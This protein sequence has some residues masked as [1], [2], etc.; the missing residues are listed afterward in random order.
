MYPL[1]RVRQEERARVAVTRGNQGWPAAAAN[2]PGG[3]QSFSKEAPLCRKAKLLG[4]T[5][6]LPMKQ[7]L[8]W[9]FYHQ[10]APGMY[11][12]YICARDHG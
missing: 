8:G 11:R 5:R 9:L 2:A 3:S 1:A 4:E 6:G 7:N 10:K 12:L